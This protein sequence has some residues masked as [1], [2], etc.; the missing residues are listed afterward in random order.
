[1]QTFVVDGQVCLGEV[2]QGRAGTGV[3]RVG[4]WERGR[5]D[6]DVADGK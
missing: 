3:V 4:E 2:K 5:E 1:M 6:G